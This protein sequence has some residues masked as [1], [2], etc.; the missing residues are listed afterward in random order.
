MSATLHEAELL[1]VRLPFVTPFRSAR[2]TTAVKDALLVRVRTDEGVGWG[3]CTAPA[4]PEY[5]GETIDG[6]R[7]A[8]RDHLLPRAFAGRR[9]RRR[10]RPRVG[11]R[12]AR[13]R[14]ARRARS[15]RRTCRSRRGSVPTATYVD[16]G[17]AVGMV[18]DPTRCDASSPRTPRPDTDASSARSSPATT[19]TRSQSVRA[20][21]GAE[22][23]VAADANGSYALDDARRLFAAVEGL[24]LQCVEQPCAPDAIAD[25]AALVGTTTTP[26]CLDESVTSAAVAADLVARGAADVLSLKVGRLGLAG[27]RRRA[28][29][30]RRKA[31]SARSPAGCSRPA[32][33]GRRCSRSPRCPASRSPATSRRRLATSAPTATSPSRSCSTA[34]GCASRPDPDSA[35]NLSPTASR[36]APSHANACRARDY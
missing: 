36:S 23:E 26:V 13:V 6:A 34:G 11:A 15:A 16:A 19:S 14:A 4:T 25:H 17:V 24:G 31:V 29:R 28:R 22:V 33:G 1:R 21:V 10:A 12:R 30:V 8:L 2:N 32:S 3:E 18:D 27:V 20:E 9:F 5:D 7:L 35:S